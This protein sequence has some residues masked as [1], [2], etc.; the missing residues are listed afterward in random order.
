MMGGL[1]DLCNLLTFLTGRR[2]VTTEYKSRYRADAYGDYAVVADFETL[3]AASLAWQHR[4]YLVSR[5][6]A[7]C[8]ALIQ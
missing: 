1:W 6:F 8:S 3:K 5:R 4:D 7:Y 2:V